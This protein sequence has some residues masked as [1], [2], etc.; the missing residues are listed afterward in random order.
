MSVSPRYPKGPH[1]NALRAFESAAR[2]G[3]FT[4]AAEELFVTSGAIAQHIKSLEEWAESPLFVRKTRGVAL[5]PL[6]EE[7]LPDFT[8]AFDSLSEAV[9]ALRS[10]ASPKKIKIATLPSIAQLWLPERLGNLRKVAPDI[11]VSVIA[12]ETRPNLTR[13]LFDVTLFFEEKPLEKGDI[14]ILQD[15]IFPV[16]IPEIGS[17]LDTVSALKNETLLHDGTWTQDWDLWLASA[18]G[19]VKFSTHG[20]IHSLFSVALEEAR[21]GGGVLMAHEA[22]VTSVL[23]SGELVSPFDHKVT[24]K[25]RL[26]MKTTPTFAIKEG[27]KLLKSVL[28]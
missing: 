6:G 17:R 5:T 12:V 21:H 11:S 20:P 27:Y 7:L 8:A 23:Q 19:E 4:S 25:R 14:E 16:C 1:L 26:V 28:F 3:S 10:K 13:E 9:Q 24:L 18:D 2:L 15:S 22:L